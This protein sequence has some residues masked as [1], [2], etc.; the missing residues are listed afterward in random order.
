MGFCGE[1]IDLCNKKGMKFNTGTF[2]RKCQRI[3][4]AASTASLR[5]PGS[6]TPLQ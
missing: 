5:V 2:C 1:D 6:E 4:M 3:F